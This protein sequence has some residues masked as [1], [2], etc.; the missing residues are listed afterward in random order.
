MALLEPQGNDESPLSVEL[1][2]W[3]K[4]AASFAED[5]QEKGSEP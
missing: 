4:H 3:E 1:F 2:Y 5:L